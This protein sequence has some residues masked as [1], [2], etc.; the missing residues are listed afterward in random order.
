MCK[1]QA[2][3]IIGDGQGMYSKSGYQRM[4]KKGRISDG[5]QAG[6]E[7][8][9]GRVAREKR[10]EKRRDKSSKREGEKGIRGYYIWRR[11]I[12]LEG[13]GSKV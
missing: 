1:R 3:H 8:I 13:L 11:R 6:E 12:L 10:Q 5:G 4:D 2:E 9:R 7:Y